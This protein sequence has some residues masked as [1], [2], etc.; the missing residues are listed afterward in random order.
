MEL[1]LRHLRVLCAIADAGSVGRAAADL[2][3][4]QPAMSTQLQR[5]ERHFGEQLFERGASGVRLT[6]YGVEVVARA[7]DVLAR[8]EAIG[9]R[10]GGS[11][12][13]TR[14]A[15]RVAATNSPI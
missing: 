11:T 5:L 2:G 4:S 1:E 7:R 3:Y 12:A 6:R 14:R 15:L 13:R 10:P 9:R 8:V